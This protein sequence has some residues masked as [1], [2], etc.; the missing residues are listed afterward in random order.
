MI[1]RFGML[2]NVLFKLFRWLFFSVIVIRFLVLLYIFGN[3]LLR[4]LFFIVLDLE[5][6]IESFFI[7]YIIELGDY[8]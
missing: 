2:M 1:F 6:I 3:I 8:Y 4:S 5:S 7:F